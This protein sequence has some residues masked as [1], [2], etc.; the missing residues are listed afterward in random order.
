MQR[1]WPRGGAGRRGRGR[2]QPR[3]GFWVGS[4]PPLPGSAGPERALW[5]EDWGRGAG[6]PDS[7]GVPGHPR[8]AEEDGTNTLP[9]VCNAGHYCREPA[10]P[11]MCAETPG[12]T[13]REDADLQGRSAQVASEPLEMQISGAKC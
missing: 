12:P 11:S 7:L 5:L 13:S 8:W 6:E 3:D 4:T 1:G 2:L 9:A 10:P